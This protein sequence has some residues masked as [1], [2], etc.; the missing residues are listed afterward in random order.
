MGVKDLWKLLEPAGRPVNLEQL[1][2][3]VLAIGKRRSHISFSSLSSQ[4]FETDV[5]VWLHQAV[6]GCRDR[7]GQPLQSAHLALLFSRICKLLHYQIK[8]VF[9]FD[10]GTP[11]L[12]QQTLVSTAA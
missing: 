1:Q 9:V 6:H 5:S 11:A 2:G 4:N 10:G 3:I 12:K 7:A 8:P